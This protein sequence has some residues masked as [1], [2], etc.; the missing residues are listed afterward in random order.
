MKLD[1]VSGSQGIE[2][3][4]TTV[5]EFLYGEFLATNFDA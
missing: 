3:P 5:S 2:T 4:D 1:H